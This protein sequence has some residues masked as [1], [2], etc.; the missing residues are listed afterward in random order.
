MMLDWHHWGSILRR[1]I[2][3]GPGYGARAYLKKKEKEKKVVII[4]SIQDS[5]FLI[6]M[7]K[8]VFCVKG[9]CVLFN[10]VNET[11]VTGLDL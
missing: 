8:G 9:I 1:S 10:K 11:L 2:S 7:L 4:R 5:F 6:V 3:F